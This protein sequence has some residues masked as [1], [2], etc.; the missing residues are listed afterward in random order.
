V[1]FLVAT[2]VAPARWRRVPLPQA[3]SSDD[4]DKTLERLR[5]LDGQ[6]KDRE[7]KDGPTLALPFRIDGRFN[8]IT[9]AIIDGR[10][11]PPGPGSETSMEKA[12]V[13]QQHLNVE[14][15]LVGLFSTATDSAFNHAGKHAHVHAVLPATHAAGHAQTF[16]LAPGA[17]LFLP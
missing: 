6:T 8:D 12:N 17:A 16:Q 3:L 5:G 2:H 11:V 10:L 9:L 4:L 1:A 14:G 15:T 13:L 7:A